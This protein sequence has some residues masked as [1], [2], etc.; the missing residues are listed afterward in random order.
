MPPVKRV[1]PIPRPAMPTS[2]VSVPVP[3]SRT[4]KSF[5]VAP[6]S[7]HGEGEK[8]ILYGTSGM[9]KTTLASLAPKPVFLGLDD[10]GRKLVDMETG[11]PIVLPHVPGL[12]TFQDVRDAMTTPGLFDDY[13]TIV[14]DNATE[15]ESWAERH[16]LSHVPLGKGSG[17][18]TSLN[19]YGYGKGYQHLYETMKLPLQDVDPLVKAGKN[20]IFIAQAA[21][22]NIANPG[23]ENFLREGPRL[24]SDKRFSVEACY[25]EWADHVLRIDYQSVSVKEHKVRGNT[26]R[27]VYSAPEPHFRAKSRTLPPE[28]SVVTFSNTKDDAIWQWI[29]RKG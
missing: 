29:F 18:A 5:V 16:I 26:E 9:G 27:V 28:A 8:I 14:I 11:E 2:S 1:P 13:D 19:D 23:G 20:I 7:G 24:Y 3:A 17:G 15:L 12:E 4:K 22:H 6:W 25:C 21:P 10:G